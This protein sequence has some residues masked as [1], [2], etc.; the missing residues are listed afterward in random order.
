V[1][2][3]L[4]EEPDPELLSVKARL[5]RNAPDGWVDVTAQVGL[6]D[7]HA[8]MGLSHGDFDAD[9]FPDLLLST[10]A[11]EY[12]ALEP[13][14]A[15]HNE[16]GRA[17]ADVTAAMGTGSLQKGHGVSFGDLDDDGDQDLLV[18]LGGAFQGDP[19][20][21]QLFVNPTNEGD[22]RH[23]HAVTLRLEGVT[24]ARSALHARIRV[25]TPSGDRW[26]VVGE[27]GSFGN[28]SLAVEVGL[29][30]DDAIERVE[31]DWPNGA[32]TETVEGVPVDAV[33]WVRQGEG[34][35]EARPYAPFVL[36]GAA[37]S[38]AHP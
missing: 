30:D 28:A 9:S 5:Y 34:V 22:H 12:D 8:T 29:G 7:I 3:A 16:G 24:V 15:Y 14:T 21:N 1:V 13:N 4:V 33:V 10:G 27:S 37:G 11:P 38:H 26:H 35:V 20:P 18:Q 17:F 23:R 32:G 19:A 6:D 25:V 36:D 31:I 2:D